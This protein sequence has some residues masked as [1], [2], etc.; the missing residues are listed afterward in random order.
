MPSIENSIVVESFV[1]HNSSA[2]EFILYLISL[3]L[4]I[5]FL[6]HLTICP[7]DDKFVEIESLELH[8]HDG[9]YKSIKYKATSGCG[10][11]L[12][13]IKNYYSSQ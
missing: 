10:Y 12:P 4:H 8:I 6:K 11:R 13:R 7:V 1:L 3:D 2:P 5:N 9:P